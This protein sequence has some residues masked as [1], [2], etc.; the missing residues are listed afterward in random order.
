MRIT[1]KK[2]AAFGVRAVLVALLL[3]AA[4][5]LLNLLTALLPQHLSKIDSSHNRLY[6]LSERTEEALRALDGDVTLYFLCSNGTEDATLRTFLDRYASLSDRIKV[7]VVDPVA[8]PTFTKTY[9]D[10]ALSNYSV[11]IAGEKRSLSIDYYDLYL[12]ENEML[13]ILTAEEYAAMASDATG[14]S[15]LTNGIAYVTADRIPK[16]YATSNH[17]ET[18][19]GS[20]LREML[21]ASSYEVVTGVSLLSLGGVPEDCDLLLLNSPK[22]DLSKDE[23]AWIS[24]YLA[25]G[26][27]LFLTTAAGN[28]YEAYER[29]EEAADGETPRTETVESAFPNLMAL[30]GE[31]GLSAMNGVIVE[32]DKSLSYSSYPVV[33]LPTVNKSHPIAEGASGS[34]MVYYTAHGIRIAD[35][36]SGVTALHTTSKTSYT[37]EVSSDDLYERTDASEEG[38]FATAVTAT[39]GKGR[40]VWFASGYTLDDS[41]DSLVSGGNHKFAVAACDHLTEK[42]DGIALPSVSLEEPMLVVTGNTAVTMA[43]IFVGVIPFSVLIGGLVFLRKRR[44]A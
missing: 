8:N 35:G 17:S 37:A 22:T 6:T 15:K 36:A 30:L 1:M 23:C 3:L 4:L 28:D 38:P 29:T 41:I 43:V 31:Y 24:A 10:A 7:K 27:R 25:G 34:T 32:E 5:V 40:L 12:W 19:L 21:K 18:A 16:I 26:G 2:P 44:R 33:L 11:I 13:G 39:A 14:E 42:G 9:T 20:D